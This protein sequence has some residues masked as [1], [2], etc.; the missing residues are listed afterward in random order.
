MFGHHLS[1]I[2]YA[3]SI[4]QAA[5]YLPAIIWNPSNPIL[6]KQYWQEVIKVAHFDVLT[7]ICPHNV[8]QM[9]GRDSRIS[10]R[11]L[12]YNLYAK[13]ISPNM[14]NFD[15]ACD[16]KGLTSIMH[17]N[18][19]DEFQHQDI[20]VNT[21]QAHNWL[22]TL[23]YGKDYM[24]FSTSD[25]TMESL[26]TNST[27]CS[28]IF[29]IHFVYSNETR[30]KPSCSLFGRKKVCEKE[31]KPTPV[32]SDID[33]TKVVPQ[34]INI[35]NIT[36]TTI[37][38]KWQKLNESRCNITF[39][40][41]CYRESESEACTEIVVQ[42]SQSTTILKHLTYNTQYRIR[43]RAHTCKGSGD[44]SEEILGRTSGLDAVAIERKE[45]KKVS[46]DATSICIGI[47]VGVVVGIATA[48]CVGCLRQWYITRRQKCK[49]DKEKY[50]TTTNAEICKDDDH[51][52]ED[53][54]ERI[55]LNIGYRESGQNWKLPKINE[56]HALY[57]S[58]A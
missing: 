44:Y 27:N 41:I 11:K 32:V 8:I 47:A 16:T 13:E 48:L 15:G 31:V 26:N 17:C 4:S 3:L 36:D 12:Y 2:L 46:I 51:E 52:K 14:E 42:S 29:R 58:D 45:C 54:P 23:E 38:I 19:P 21:V 55:A 50:H 5:Y 28:M 37:G 43:M 39:F 6:Q 40:G 25:G 24:F 30:P 35:T 9:I 10:P 22:P 1:I 53:E 20:T 57:S 33:C 56:N 18:K 34:E 7:F 49:D